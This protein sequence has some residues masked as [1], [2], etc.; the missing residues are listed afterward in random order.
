MISV[1]DIEFKKIRDEKWDRSWWELTH[2]LTGA[3]FIGLPT[4]SKERCIERL[5]RIVNP[6][7]VE[8]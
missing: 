1:E 8:E 3:T 4:D 6:K 7:K 2:A 5:N